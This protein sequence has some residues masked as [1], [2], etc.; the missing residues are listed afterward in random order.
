MNTIYNKRVQELIKIGSNHTQ[1]SEEWYRVRHSMITAS[2]ACTALGKNPYETE[3]SLLAKKCTPHTN[4]TPD[5]T[6]NN[7]MSWGNAFES[8]ATQVFCLKNDMRTENVYHT[9]CIRSRWDTFLGASPDG[10]L[11]DGRL[12]EIKCPVTRIIQEQIPHMYWVQMQIQMEVCRL[13]TCV[14]VQCKFHKYD[15]Y[16]D[17]CEYHGYP[18]TDPMPTEDVFLG[19][20]GYL[21]SHGW[22]WRLVVYQEQTVRRNPSWYRNVRPILRYFWNKVLFYRTNDGIEYVQSDKVRKQSHTQT[23]LMNRTKEPWLPFTSVRNVMVKDPFLDIVEQRVK[24]NSLPLPPPFNTIQYQIDPISRFVSIV[25]ERSRTFLESVIDTWKANH[26]LSVIQIWDSDQEYVLSKN[27]PFYKSTRKAMDQGY[28]I[29]YN[30]VLHNKKNYTYGVVDVLIRTESLKIVFPNVTLQ[31]V[32]YYHPS[33]NEYTVCMVK[34]MKL[35]LCKDGVH[36]KH[37]PSID[38][39]RGTSYLMNQAVGV[40]QGRTSH[41]SYLLG[42]RYEYVSGGVRVMGYSCFDRV[43]VFDFTYKDL[44]VGDHVTYGLS[45]VRYL[46]GY[47]GGGNSYVSNK[48]SVSKSNIFLDHRCYPN[49]CNTQDYPYSRAKRIF[50]ETYGEITS[51]WHCTEK[52]R[53]H[54][55][56]LGIHSWNDP[57]CTVDTLGVSSEYYKTRIREILNINRQTDDSIRCIGSDVLTCSDT[58]RIFQDS[59][60]STV[61]IKQNVCYIDFETVTIHSRT[62]SDNNILTE[63]TTYIA[64]IGCGWEDSV[65]KKWRFCSFVVDEL[66][67]QG[68]RRI[69]QLFYEHIMQLNSDTNTKTNP[70]LIHWGHAESSILDN[71]IIRHTETTWGNL[72]PFLVDLCNYFKKHIIVVRGSLTYGLKPIAR[73]LYQNNRIKTIWPDSSGCES[74]MD[75]M[76][77]LLDIHKDVTGRGGCFFAHKDIHDIVKYNEI[78]CRVLYDIVKVVGICIFGNES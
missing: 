9:G 25:N 64:M 47:D 16:K 6:S 17:Y 23:H 37:T 72:K 13:D 1:G 62:F 69:I 30:A 78:D 74:G 34:D 50:A 51:V 8:V 57:K 36:V 27:C 41:V 18:D 75:A 66:T 2:D 65:T 5:H 46:R 70:V 32:S 4:D 38:S 35:P 3:Q 39:I 11:P 67:T 45:W 43:G 10:V 44:D 63:Q 15:T 49:M 77:Q 71:A 60:G 54:A 61:S 7:H 19:N 22:F 20:H 29:I 26:S 55:M 58:K 59:S 76:V 40:I 31:P 14:F 48:P 52:N 68:E 12:L 42:S 53:K 28:D 73:A 21:H 24:G 33:R 56:D